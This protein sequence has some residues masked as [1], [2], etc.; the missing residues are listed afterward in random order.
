MDLPAAVAFVGSEAQGVDEAGEGGEG[1]LMCEHEADAKPRLRFGGVV[2]WGHEAS[3]PGA[4]RESTRVV[5]GSHRAPQELT[6]WLHGTAPLPFVS[7]L[8]G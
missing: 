3:S 6:P 8:F 1:E 5:A 7:T 2:V 4:G